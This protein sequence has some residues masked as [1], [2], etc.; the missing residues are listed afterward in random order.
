MKLEVVSTTL[1][2]SRRYPSLVY[3]Y[4]HVQKILLIDD[5]YFLVGEVA[6]DIMKRFKI[7]G[8]GAAKV[9]EKVGLECGYAFLFTNIEQIKK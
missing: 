9:V 4:V 6:T 3:N 5:V 7:I 1:Q 2:K 8:M